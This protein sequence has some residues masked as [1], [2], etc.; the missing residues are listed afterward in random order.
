MRATRVHGL[1]E[2]A[3]DCGRVLDGDLHFVT[4]ETWDNADGSTTLRHFHERCHRAMRS[5]ESVQAV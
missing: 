2:C 3:A 5:N 1:R 4:L